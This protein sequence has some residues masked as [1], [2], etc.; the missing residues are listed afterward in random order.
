MIRAIDCK[1][2]KQ[3]AAQPLLPKASDSIYRPFI[4]F[5][6]EPE[7]VEYFYVDSRQTSSIIIDCL[8]GASDAT[9]ALNQLKLK[10][11]VDK[12]F[13]LRHRAHNEFVGLNR[14]ILLIFFYVAFQ[15]A[16]I[17]TNG[18]RKRFNLM[19]LLN[20]Q[21]S[22]IKMRNTCIQKLSGL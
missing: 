3:Q 16:A 4:F 8:V 6:Q 19:D 14:F 21:S 18:C 13:H 1:S 17:Y 10:W 5:A 9:A 2:D 15:C 12:S 20:I 22:Q 7:P 11:I